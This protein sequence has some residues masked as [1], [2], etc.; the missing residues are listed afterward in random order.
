MSQYGEQP[1][2]PGV[3]ILQNNHPPPNDFFING[4]KKWKIK[5]INSVFSSSFLFQDFKFQKIFSQGG[6]LR[7]SLSGDVCQTK[8]HLQKGPKKWGKIWFSG[9]GQGNDFKT[10]YTPLRETANRSALCLK[11]LCLLQIFY[12]NYKK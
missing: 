5:H 10:K 6:K 7:R 4:G 3:Y 1:G 12:K 2:K 11:L 9:E 8:K